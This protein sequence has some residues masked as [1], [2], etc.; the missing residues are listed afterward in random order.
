MI[1]YILKK[2]RRKI[3]ECHA[4]DRLSY[5]NTGQSLAAFLFIPLIHQVVN[6]DIHKIPEKDTTSDKDC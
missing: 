4:R 2:V 3:Y 1:P 6:S 5:I